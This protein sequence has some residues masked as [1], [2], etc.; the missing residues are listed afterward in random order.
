M[1][2]GFI[3]TIV[4]LLILSL[5]LV[6]IYG[7]G[8][9]M[10]ASFDNKFGGAL[11]AVKY[12]G[13]STSTTP[14]SGQFL[15]GNASGTY[16]VGF[17]TAGTNV[18]LSTSSGG[19]TINAGVATWSTTTDDAIYY[20]N[21]VIIGGSSTSSGLFWFSTST[22]LTVSATSSFSTTSFLGE[23][24]FDAST[25]LVSAT[26]TTDYEAVPK[27]Y[28]DDNTPGVHYQAT[29][30]WTNPSV[31]DVWEDWDISGIVP[32][33]T[34]Y[35]EVLIW[36]QDGNTVAGVD[37]ASTTNHY[38]WVGPSGVA[39]P[40]TVAVGSSRIIERFTGGSVTDASTTII[41]YW[42]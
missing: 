4:T 11:V 7:Y 28:V 29:T 41:G 40:Y 34:K 32:E 36:R 24:T 35:V 25:T 17:L 13:T 42:K 30:T 23:V 15:I 21:D 18:T 6:A 26:P 14:E 10:R 2:K 19:V 9:Y 8:Q 22:G 12:G 16:S 3:A 38:T 5:G 31:Y 20:I 27:V 39:G 33:N 1:N 37:E